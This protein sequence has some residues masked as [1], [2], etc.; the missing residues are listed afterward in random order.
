[1]CTQFEISS[2]IVLPD[3]NV[4][5]YNQISKIKV[6][7]LKDTVGASFENINDARKMLNV[8][9]CTRIWDPTMSS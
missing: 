2:S 5:I 4:T 9:E 3:I 1:M 8:S 6:I 7:M